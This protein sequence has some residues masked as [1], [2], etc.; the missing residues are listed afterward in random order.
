[1]VRLYAEAEVAVVPS[2]YEGFSLPAIEAMSCGVPL[3]ATTGGALAEVVGPDGGVV[4]PPGD[5]G[6][7]AIAIRD[8]LDDRA[9]ALDMGARAR[10]RV[11]QRFTWR[12]AALGCVDQYRRVIAGC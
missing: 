1:M 8:L 2:L 4:V 5:A 12:A 9:R 11:E 3:V 7:L 6:S 10:K